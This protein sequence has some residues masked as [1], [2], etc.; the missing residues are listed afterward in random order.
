MKAMLRGL[1][2]VS[3]LHFSREFQCFDLS[4]F[5][6]EDCRYDRSTWFI[7]VKIE[8]TAGS[9]YEKTGVKSMEGFWLT[10]QSH[11]ACSES[12]EEQS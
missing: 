8:F 2:I 9:T 11:V 3:Q 4:L 5:E 12:S 6:M 10:S 7:S 1:K